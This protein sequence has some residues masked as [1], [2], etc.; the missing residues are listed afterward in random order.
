MDRIVPRLRLRLPGYDVRGNHVFNGG[1]PMIV[2][3]YI[4]VGLM[5]LA[6]VVGLA[7]IPGVFLDMLRAWGN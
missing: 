2:L 5:G 3:A 1:G 7:L 6:I 4:I